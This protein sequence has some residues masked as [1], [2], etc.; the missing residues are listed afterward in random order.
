MRADTIQIEVRPTEHY[1]HILLKGVVDT[2]ELV[3]RLTRTYAALPD[4]WLY[5]QL[6]DV[7]ALIN[8]FTHKNFLAISQMW[9]DIAANYRK[10][11][12]AVVTTDPFRLE[13]TRVFAPQYQNMETLAFPTVELAAQWLAS[14][15]SGPMVLT[16]ST[17]Q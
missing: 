5:D 10:L 2:E 1:I 3:R 17:G 9:D 12:F 8:V 7:R 4:P 14:D 16:A 13:R 11:R 15:A 6:H